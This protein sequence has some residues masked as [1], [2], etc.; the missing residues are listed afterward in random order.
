MNKIFNL[1]NN[2][3]VVESEDSIV[4]LSYGLEVLSLSD[5]VLTVK[6][7]DRISTTSR[8]HI[9]SFCDRYGM[10]RPKFTAKVCRY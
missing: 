4:L 8:K 2:A 7:E 6:N 1:S 3:I 9:Y 5:G 10:N